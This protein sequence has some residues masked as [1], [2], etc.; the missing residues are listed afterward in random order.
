LVWY[1]DYTLEKRDTG[2]AQKNRFLKRL[3]KN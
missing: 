1:L 3:N 2:W